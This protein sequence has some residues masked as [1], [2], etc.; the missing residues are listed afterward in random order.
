MAVGFF[1]PLSAPALLPLMLS[2]HDGDPWALAHNRTHHIRFGFLHV[3]I[4]DFGLIV[5]PQLT[6]T[7]YWH[8][9]KA[10]CGQHFWKDGHVNSKRH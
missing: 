3:K 9:V 5:W 10:C 1:V 8:G 6:I 7:V 2:L 4:T